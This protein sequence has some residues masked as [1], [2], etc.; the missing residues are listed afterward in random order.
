MKYIK[1]WEYGDLV[2]SDPF[3]NTIVYDSVELIND[4]DDIIPYDLSR[5]LRNI[6]DTVTNIDF[7][8]NKLSDALNFNRGI[9]LRDLEIDPATDIKTVLVKNS[10]N[11]RVRKHFLRVTPGVVYLNN[12]NI[13]IY[14]NLSIAERQLFKILK[15]ENTI[16]VDERVIINYYENTDKFDIQIK[17]MNSSGMLQNY[18]FSK[19]DYGDSISG[20]D[21][22]MEA[23]LAVYGDSVNFSELKD[24]INESVENINLEENVILN[25]GDSLFIGLDENCDLVSDVR[26]VYFPLYHIKTSLVSNEIRVDELNDLRSSIGDTI[27]DNELI[28][29]GTLANGE[30]PTLNEDGGI[31]TTGTT[32]LHTETFS[33]YG[34][35]SLSGRFSATNNSRLY[36]SNSISTTN[37]NNLVPGNTYKFSIKIKLNSSTSYNN[38]NISF[39]EFLENQTV[40]TTVGARNISGWQEL[41]LTKE[42]NSLSS[43]ANISLD[44]KNYGNVSFDNV[45]LK[46]IKANS[47]VSDT[48]EIRNISGDTLSI[49]VIQSDGDSQITLSDYITGDT[50][51][52]D[53]IIINEDFVNK[54]I[55]DRIEINSIFTDYLKNNN[56]NNIRLNGKIT[57]D[58]IELDTLIL[59]NLLGNALNT[60]AN[61]RRDIRENVL[62]SNYII[63]DPDEGKLLNFHNTGNIT[64]NLPALNNSYN[65]FLVNIRKSEDNNTLTLNPGNFNNINGESEYILT[66][67]REIV[68]VIWNGNNWIIISNFIPSPRPISR[69]GT[70]Q[71]SIENILSFFNI[72]SIDSR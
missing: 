55:G 42:L 68:T 33:T 14:P 56:N 67:F 7:I 2:E 58:T 5:P 36:F 24:T 11:N 59:E 35:D 29:N 51:I 63:S 47:F 57:G 25:G 62:S 66:E 4:N 45:S 72:L 40:I 27:K 19:G 31:I 69:G 49:N 37:L 17:K 50:F 28:Y 53:N 54:F 71:T 65:G 46:D 10:S 39:H 26:Q 1:S 8:I 38:V 43:G 61:V 21:T 32:S 22:G 41:I 9:F 18:N 12:K 34:G 70:G 15:L 23:L 13:P 44:I 20:F 16:G 3:D 30:Y 64:V 48:G 60:P 6:Y 52:F